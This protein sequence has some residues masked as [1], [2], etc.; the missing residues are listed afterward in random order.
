MRTLNGQKQWSKVQYSE[1]KRMETINILT[2]P[3]PISLVSLRDI[4][5]H[6]QYQ[7]S[8]LVWSEHGLIDGIL[9]LTQLFISRHSS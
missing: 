3:S 1:G 5:H 2:L 7:I 9:H 6:S 8:D 4:Y